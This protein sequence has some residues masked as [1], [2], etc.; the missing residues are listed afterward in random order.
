M[1]MPTRAEVE[2]IKARY[3]KGT[4]IENIGGICY[5]IFKNL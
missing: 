5:G 1:E 3:P 4:V 2:S